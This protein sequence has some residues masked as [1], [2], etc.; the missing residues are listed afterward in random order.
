MAN[1]IS[2]N[3]CIT[4]SGGTKAYKGDYINAHS[5]DSIMNIAINEKESIITSSISR[6]VYDK[7]APFEKDAVISYLY[8]V[9]PKILQRLSKRFS[10][11]TN[12]YV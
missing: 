8:N 11:I 6:S 1:F 10:L 12:K 9:D 3:N 4:L 5:V 7:L 2:Y